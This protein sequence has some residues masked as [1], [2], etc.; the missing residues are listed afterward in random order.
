MNDEDIT[1]YDSSGV[2]ETEQWSGGEW[3]IINFIS[4]K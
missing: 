1:R 2:Q 3:G 4:D